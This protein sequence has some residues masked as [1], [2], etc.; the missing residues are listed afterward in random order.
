MLISDHELMRWDSNLLRLASSVLF[1][2]N[3]PTTFLEPSPLPGKELNEEWVTKYLPGV[4][5]EAIY[6]DVLE[7]GCGVGRVLVQCLRGAPRT[8]VGLE[9]S[10]FG[11]ALCRGRFWNWPHTV[12]L[13]V[14]DDA[15]EI[16]SRKDFS[17]I[18]GCSTFIHMTAERITQVV[19]WAVQR[20]APNGYLCVD[21]RTGDDAPPATPPEGWLPGQNWQT[22]GHSPEWLVDLFTECGLT[23][24]A[25]HDVEAKRGYVTGHR[26]A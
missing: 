26:P 9:V 25:F 4:P 19:R 21:V 17:L 8:Y 13:H 11:V 16:N 6:G 2:R 15:A 23:D 5:Q 7:V 1:V 10:R 20:L 3:S 22:F 14:I 24:V 12:F 18:F